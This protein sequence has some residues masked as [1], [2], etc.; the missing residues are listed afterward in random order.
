MSSIVLIKAGLATTRQ[1]FSPPLGIM[2]LAS[3]LRD[4]FKDIELQLIDMSARHLSVEQAIELALSFSPD[5]LGLSAMSFEAQ[6]MHELAARAKARQP[7]LPVVAGGPHPST[8][9]EAVLEDPNL[10][11]IVIG[12][13]ELTFRELALRILA[14]ESAP[15]EV[16]GI[17]FRR[18]GKPALT[19]AREET[20][21][22][23]SL[24]LPAYDLIDL[25]RYWDLPRFGTAY[26][27]RE[28]AALS[29]SRACPYRC[30]YCHRIFG[31]RYRAQS[32]ELALRDLATLR[33]EHGVREIIF[34]DDCFNLDRK[35]VA[36]ICDGMIERGLD[37]SISFP[38]GLRGDVM[39]R[40]TLDKLK[41]AG[42]YR[43]TY[44]VESGSPR[45]QAFI[46]KN[47]KLEVLQEVIAE[48]D[49]R[50]IMVD[51]FFMVGFPGETREEIQMTFDY[52]L[53][54]RLHTANFWFVT[55]FPGTELHEQAR[56][57]GLAVPEQPDHLHYFD[58]ET[59][60]SQVPAAELKRMVQKTFLRFYLKPWRLWRIFKLFPNK[61]Q[62]PALLL[63]FLKIS[64]TWK[65]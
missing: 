42:T 3:Y 20:V 26:A 55:P 6:V 16:K 34:V 18:N 41:K 61:R 49:R 51:G 21:D 40:T 65:S 50:D 13:G 52:A 33:D 19:P 1:H 24:S 28:Y 43:I 2:S 25:P 8:A 32:P 15:E 9:R 14:G 22:L 39:D 37:F 59:D 47:V 12:E 53:Y 4:Q 46:K 44:A 31:T 56:T 10:D 45:V 54:S 30:T 5:L 63:R 60:L 38:N 29:T 58:P 27:R 62:L 48:T 35:R 11:F 57:L 7:A 36:D 23:N 17:G 64:A